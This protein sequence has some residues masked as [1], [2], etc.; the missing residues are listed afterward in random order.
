MPLEFGVK[1][2]Y[3]PGG[4]G[5]ATSVGV[6]FISTPKVLEPALFDGMDPRTGARVLPSHGY[7]LETYE[8]VWQ[9][10]KKYFSEIV[11]ALCRCNNIQ[12]DV[13]RK[14]TPPIINSILKPDCLEEGKHIGQL[15]S[16]YNATFNVEVCGGVNLA[17]SLAS[18]KKNVYEDRKF[19][20]DE[21]KD[22]TMHNFGKGIEE[23]RREVDVDVDVGVDMDVETERWNRIHKLCM[24]TPKYGNADPYRRD[25]L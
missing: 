21:L 11:L 1:K 14:I 15:G 17:N 16:R 25:I 12:H 23:E 4:A 5:P 20:L 13:W 24:E 19:G 22:A 10:F 18:L 8:E 9:A 2:Y 7:K 3:I 6:H